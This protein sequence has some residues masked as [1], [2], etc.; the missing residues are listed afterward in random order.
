[1]YDL[2]ISDVF[3]AYLRRDGKRNFCFFLRLDAFYDCGS[4]GDAF[5]SIWNIEGQIFIWYVFRKGLL[6]TDK[7]WPEIKDLCEET[8]TFLGHCWIAILKDWITLGVRLT[9]DSAKKM[10]SFEYSFRKPN[11]IELEGKEK[12]PKNEFLATAISSGVLDD[13]RLTKFY[14]WVFIRSLFDTFKAFGRRL[15]KG[16]HYKKTELFDE[17]KGVVEQI[18]EA[19]N[20]PGFLDLTEMDLQ[21]LATPYELV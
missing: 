11:V 16:E 14:S 7:N 3:Q 1:M 9:K 19:K 4:T 21:E 12:I 20:W 2:S 17:E 15:F 10:I 6:S 13:C 18:E 8:I 5:T